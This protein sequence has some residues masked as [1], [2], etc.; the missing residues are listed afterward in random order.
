MGAT[1]PAAKGGDLPAG[2]AD[3]YERAKG[4]LFHE[5][6]EHPT[7]CGQALVS[8]ACR[9]CYGQTGGRS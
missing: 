9:P 8:G 2:S 1:E 6:R 5:A 7:A 4:A 3:H